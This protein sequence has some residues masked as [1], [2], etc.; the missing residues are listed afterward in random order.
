MRR[1]T[2]LGPFLPAGGW[3]GA[4]QVCSVSRM[5]RCLLIHCCSATWPFTKA[6][7]RGRSFIA[8]SRDWWEDA[9]AQISTIAHS[10]AV[11]GMSLHLTPTERLWWKVWGYPADFIFLRKI[12]KIIEN[13]LMQLAQFGANSIWLK[14]KKS[15]QNYPYTRE[16]INT[17]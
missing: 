6:R 1:R 4:E 10:V 12:A 17:H 11:I 5:R 13:M 14:K 2:V 15:R 16:I 9:H 7:N 3:P 8:V